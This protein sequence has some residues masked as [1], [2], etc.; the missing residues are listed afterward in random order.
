MSCTLPILDEIETQ[1]LDMH[2]IEIV[3]VNI[4]IIV[5]LGVLYGKAGKLQAQD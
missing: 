5:T 2:A 3:I 1:I 4:N